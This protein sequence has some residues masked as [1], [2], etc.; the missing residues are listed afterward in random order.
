[1]TFTGGEYILP[2]IFPEIFSEFFFSEIF[3]KIFLKL[4]C[5]DRQS[6][7]STLT[8]IKSIP[9]GEASDFGGGYI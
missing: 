2:E 3:Q 5:H 1:M 7:I 6:S 8:Y 9:N 4:S